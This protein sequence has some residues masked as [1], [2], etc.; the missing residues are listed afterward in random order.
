MY[1]NSEKF[2]ATF[3]RVEKEIKA[4]MVYRKDMSFSRSVRILSN[5]NTIIRRYSE[6]LLE[7]AELRNAIVHNKV[8]MTHAI[9]E[10]HDSVVER[11]ELIEKE[12]S[13]PL[14]VMP[15]YSRAVHTFQ[16]N[17]PLEKLLTIIRDKGISKFPIYNERVFKGL[18]TQKGITRWLAENLEIS[19]STIKET[20]LRDVLTYQTVDNYQFISQDTTQNDASEY[21][22]GNIGEG[23]RLE[24]LLITKS[25]DSEEKLLGI[26]TPW[27]IV[28]AQEEEK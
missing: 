23:S 18:L 25:G 20:R 9:A 5:S 28:H 22:R 2:L 11:I 7:Y 12:L 15:A 8:D 4:L 17:D 26:I 21:F 14:K 16:E 27:D 3:N 13:E 24:A 10:P 6:D 1:K 19:H